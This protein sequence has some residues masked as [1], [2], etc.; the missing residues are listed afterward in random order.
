MYCHQCGEKLE[1][2]SRFCP[3]CGADLQNEE[4]PYAM[5]LRQDQSLQQKKEPMPTGKKV[6][7]ILAAVLLLTGLFF[8]GR[9]TYD[10]YIYPY[11]RYQEATELMEA[12]SYEDA[13]PIYEE[14]G[15]YED[16]PDL[17]LEAKYLFGDQL[18][19]NGQ[20]ER[21]IS[22]Y[23][24]LPGYRDCKDRITECN[25]QIA[26][27]VYRLPDYTQAK[28]LFL[29]LV[30]YKDTRDLIVDCD[31]GLAKEVFDAGDYTRA[32]DA[33]LALADYKDS[34]TYYLE[35]IYQ[36]AISEHDAKDY[37][38]SLDHLRQLIAEN[39]KD[40]YAY[41]KA[42]TPLLAEE[43]VARFDH[44]WDKAQQYLSYMC[45]FEYFTYEPLNE[46]NREK[47]LEMVKP[48]S[49]SIYHDRGGG[50]YSFGTGG[51]YKVTSD[52][53][54]C[55]TVRHVVKGMQKHT[56]RLTF[57]DGTRV[58]IPM[59]AIYSNENKNLDFAM[60]RI[61][62]DAIPPQL[63]ITF[64]EMYYDEAV[65]DEL[66]PGDGLIIHANKWG[67]K[68]DKIFDTEYIGDDLY[69]S[70]HSYDE[71]PYE[72]F[73]VTRHDAQGGQSGGPIFDLKG[74]AVA[75][76]DFTYWE[77]TGGKTYYVDGQVKL[78]RASELFERREEMD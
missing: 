15:E 72:D 53:V 73:I 78:K 29:K 36:I 11:L 55:L 23:E 71:D 42:M 26:L 16:S 75:L 69:A 1:E 41:A 64:K 46:E 45:E 21:A 5:G 34:H 49:F 27:K 30:P 4:N 43:Y 39:Y 6:A 20:Y 19:K 28:E 77:K 14:L 58:D 35:C 3:Y 56:I 25:Y 2:E 70:T 51:I 8:L 37:L 40:S 47:T 52:Y 67:G 18:Q 76:V 7:L 32:A 22:W 44:D 31:Y 48:I 38:A 9:Y 17:L 33:F 63:L 12:R 74:R 68:T 62:V 61:P 50:A 65:Y 59:H 57:Y 24:Q 66:K 60:F 54:Y 13:I 10:N